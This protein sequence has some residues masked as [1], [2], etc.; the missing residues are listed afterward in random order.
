MS[1]QH[2]ITSDEPY[3]YDPAV[4]SE[5][6]RV[7]RKSR[8]IKSCFP[9]RH[10][11]VRC[12][13]HVP[14]SNCVRRDH[15]S[16]CRTVD[17]KAFEV[18]SYVPK[19]NTLPL[20]LSERNITRL[21]LSPSQSISPFGQQVL[22]QYGVL[23]NTTDNHSTG[24]DINAVV[25]RLEKIEQQ[26]MALKSELLHGLHQRTPPPAPVPGRDQSSRLAEYSG[27]VG[28]SSAETL[29][30]GLVLDPKAEPPKPRGQRFIEGAT[31]A[32]IFLGAGSDPPSALG[33][34]PEATRNGNDVPFDIGMI[35]PDQLAPRTYPFT[36][37]W[38]SEAGLPDVCRTLPEDL[39]IIRYWQDFETYVHPFY[40]A[41]VALEKFR[42]SIHSFIRRRST[43]PLG[44]SGSLGP[45]TDEATD[46]SWLALLFAVLACGVQFSNDVA[47]ER[48][49]RSKVFICSSFQCL[50]T[51]NLFNKTNITQIQAL[52]LVGH[53][54]RN[55][56]ETNSAWIFTGVTM[57]LAQS[58][59][60][61]ESATT[62]DPESGEKMSQASKLWWI[63]V[64]Q[65]TF[66]SFTYDRPPNSPYTPSALTALSS[67][68]GT[69]GNSFAESIFAICHIILDWT[70]E[71]TLAGGL[72]STSPGHYYHRLE[73]YKRRLEGVHHNA[74]PFLRDKAFCRTLQD[75]LERLALHIHVTY[76]ICRIS[77]LYLDSASTA[78]GGNDYET[79]PVQEETVAMQ[80]IAHATDSVQSFLEIYR[81]SP[82]VCRSW[83]F[84]HNAVSSA[85]PVKKMMMKVP[86]RHPGGHVEG[87]G[88]EE[89]E[90]GTAGRF[91]LLVAQ[92]IG[93]L[94]KEEKQ[95]EWHDA[96]TNVR[97]FGPYS[98]ALRALKETYVGVV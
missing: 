10:R 18:A 71:E 25:E 12:N 58:I 66:L 77:R 57:R 44:R 39:D 36:N 5:I 93:V 13:G 89:V 83:A 8:D 72:E 50:R 76:A 75:H 48:D 3:R 24:G 92:L 53:C 27:I 95:S 63:L 65:D 33:C 31:G 32:T 79:R 1:S 61:H 82:N 96:D 17:S 43:S 56:L 86:G 74:Q 22:E 15:A 64:W 46:P 49:L 60:L 23:Q 47:R 68:T 67:K 91:E 90:R 4:V 30:C 20:E 26:I 51:A 37:L 7:K 78:G 97:Y 52:A 9:C 29:T 2:S 35:M 55:N 42:I 84:V 38:T 62:Q 88:V 81:L 45:N 19:T 85:L 14:C 40:P 69:E 94:E 21:P 16:L 80:Y 98:R 11:K 87:L 34:I 73:L 54:L 6:L 28:S 59:G 41:L 70:R